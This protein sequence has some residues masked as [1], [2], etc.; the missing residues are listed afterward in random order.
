MS[1]LRIK[2]RKTA[3]SELEKALNRVDFFRIFHT[4]ALRFGFEHFGILQLGNEK[5]MG[6][7]AGKLALHDLPSGLAEEY[8]KRHR[9]TDSAVFKS[10]HQSTIPSLWRAVDQ[11]PNQGNLL[12]QL[13]FDLLACIPVHGVNGARHAVFYLGDAEDLPMPGLQELTFETISAFDHFYRRVLVSKA[14]MGLTPREREIL[15]W[16]SHGKTASE[17]ALIVS[18]SE[19]TINSHTATILKKLDVVNRTQMV[20]KAIREQIIQ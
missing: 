5:D 18:V 12:T 4:L 2:E 14:G 15:R 17:I 20:A 11:T 3:E 9:F 7:L 19:H 6:S 1:S 13:G 16:I 10:L 8:D